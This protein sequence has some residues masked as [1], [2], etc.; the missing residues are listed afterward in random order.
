MSF[1]RYLSGRD[2]VIGMNRR[3]RML[4]HLL[5]DRKLYPSADDK[6][7]TKAK[8]A[9]HGLPAPR[10]L[11]VFESQFDTRRVPS[12]VAGL[13][14]FVVKPARGLRGQGILLL[15]RE[16]GRLRDGSGRAVSPEEVQRHIRL[17]LCGEFSLGNREDRAFIEERIRPPEFMRA[18]HGGGVA[19]IRVIAHRGVPV[20][21]MVRLPT[22]RSGGRANLHAGGVGVGIEL[23]TG[24]AVHAI[25]GNRPA[26][27]HP[28]TGSALRGWRVPGWDGILEVS[29][30]CYDAVPLGYL[31]V[32]VI[33]DA[34]RGPLVVEL[35]VRPGLNI[36]LANRRGLWSAIEAEA[37][38]PKEKVSR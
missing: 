34:E 25:M 29:R 30:R 7:L 33:L 31:G 36:Q 11:A 23:E 24:R 20:M 14:E 1:L 17:V 35:N 10:T 22:K 38:K 9:E 2:G 4:I 6:I 15:S 21:A 26:D 3:N 32:D 37:K 27:R 18:I 5:N 19:D 13:G 16:D 12:I 8:L 28:D